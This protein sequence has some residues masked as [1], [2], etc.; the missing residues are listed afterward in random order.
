MNC[1]NS[2][3]EFASLGN[4]CLF[5]PITE[6][7]YSLNCLNSNPVVYNFSNPQCSGNYTSGTLFKDE[8]C[9]NFEKKLFTVSP[10]Y[11]IAQFTCNGLNLVSYTDSNCDGS[12]V[13]FPEGAVCM[14]D[15]KY[16]YLI[17]CQST[18]P[19]ASPT[20]APSISPTRFPTSSPSHSP[21]TSPTKATSKPSLSPVTSTPTTFPTKSPS[22]H[23][24]TNNPTISA[25][26][27]DPT[28]MRPSKAPSNNPSKAPRFSFPTQSP[29]IQSTTLSPTSQSNVA[30]TDVGIG[31]GTSV[32]IVA[33]G[34][35]V[36]VVFQNLQKEK[37]NSQGPQW[38]IPA[39]FQ[40]PNQAI[41]RHKDSIEAKNPVFKQE[42]SGN[43]KQEQLTEEQILQKLRN[44]YSKVDPG[45]NDQDIQDLA[46][47]AFFNGEAALYQKLRKKFGVDPNIIS[48]EGAPREKLVLSGEN[49]TQ[50]QFSSINDVE[51]I[52]DDLKV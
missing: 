40:A 4:T 18:K 36:F 30:G 26:T 50:K 16:D 12:S 13:Q 32:G 15:S 38:L 48:E 24:P 52:G 23:V 47:W 21:S 11:T 41:N 49:Q 43:L 9:F 46:K 14:T 44:F 2:T 29:T 42:S 20:S 37:R 25:P 8:T 22:T 6:T 45:K 1:P 10:Y 34:L 3:G 17:S 28:T 27:K 7:G 35:A 39:E 33:A 19:T 31:I 51:H 5:D